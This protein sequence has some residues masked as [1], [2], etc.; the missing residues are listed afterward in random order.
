VLRPDEQVFKRPSWR[1]DEKLRNET[2]ADVLVFAYGAAP[3]A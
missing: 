2:D 3:V 1:S